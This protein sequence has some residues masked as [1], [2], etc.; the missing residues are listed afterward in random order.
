MEPQENKW[1]A[2]SCMHYAR[3]YVSVAVLH[4][5]LYAMGGYDGERRTATT[6]RYDPAENQWTLVADMH[7]A[8]SDACAAVAFDRTLDI[9]NS[10]EL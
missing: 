8:R 7:E 4:G 1:C 3:C 10:K 5:S 9:G 6:E 2:K